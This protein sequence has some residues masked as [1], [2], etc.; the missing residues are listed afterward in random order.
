MK[1]GNPPR[2]NLRQRRKKDA[3]PTSRFNRDTSRG[4]RALDGLS[5]RNRIWLTN[6]R[7]K[8][9]NPSQKEGFSFTFQETR[10]PICFPSRILSKSF[11]FLILKIIIGIFS[12][13]HRANAVASITLRSFLSTFFQMSYNSIQENP[14]LIGDE[15]NADMSS[16][17][18]GNPALQSG[19]DAVALLLI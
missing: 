2:C 11:K 6:L 14:D 12:R 9:I 7:S 17:F 13:M 3:F 19:E 15:L 1:R 5:P 16:S 4:L 18:K 8:W 10:V